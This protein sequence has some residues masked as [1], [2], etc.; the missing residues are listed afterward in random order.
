MNTLVAALHGHLSSIPVLADHEPRLTLMGGPGSFVVVRFVSYLSAAYSKIVTVLYAYVDESYIEGEVH[1]IGVLVLNAHQN[2]MLGLALDKIVFETNKRNPSVSMDIELH[3]QQLF[4]RSGEWSCLRDT[5][6]I[7]F[8]VYRAAVG[9]I[10]ASGGVWIVGGVRRIDRLAQRYVNPTPPH[11]IALQYAL[12]RVHDYAESQ[13]E[14]VVIIADQVPDAAHHQARINQFQA[15][16]RTPGWNHR[17]LSRIR[18]EFM[19]ED[20][21]SHRALQAVDMLTYVYLRKRFVSNAH[22]RPTLEIQK[23][24]DLA[25]PLLHSCYIWTP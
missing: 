10:V 12:E 13:G 15:R 14:D 11:E 24:S 18:P 22:P 16:G 5:P 21:R 3:G 4:Q 23:L 8:T 2:R 17:D 7:A 9:K 19:W 25:R 6:R 1:L 20:S